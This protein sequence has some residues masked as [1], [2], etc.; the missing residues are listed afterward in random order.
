MK[1]QQAIAELYES[2]LQLTYQNVNKNLFYGLKSLLNQVDNFQMLSDKNIVHDNQQSMSVQFVYK[3][4]R[5][6]RVFVGVW[7]NNQDID[8][9]RNMTVTVFET[10][11]EGKTIEKLDTNAFFNPEDKQNHQIG[12]DPSIRTVEE[13]VEYVRSVLDRSDDDRNDEYVQPV[14]PAPKAKTQLKYSLSDK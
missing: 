3:G 7:F 5:T 14:A 4:T 6:I 10:T 13:F 8:S 1:D 12:H 9:I 11:P 2:V